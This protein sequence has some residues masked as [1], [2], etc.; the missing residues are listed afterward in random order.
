MSLRALPSPDAVA[1]FRGVTDL[2]LSRAGLHSLPGY[3]FS[4]ASPFADTL[5]KL[6]VSFNALSALPDELERCSKLKILF[7]AKNSFEALPAVLGK[8]PSLG[9]VSFK[10]NRIS[11]VPENSLPPS[12]YWLILTDNGISSLPSSIGRLE[13]LR[14]C[15]LSCNRLSALPESMANCT[16]LELLRLADND[17]SCIPPFLLS[18]PRLAWVALGGNLL[19]PNSKTDHLETLIAEVP[20]E[21]VVPRDAVHLGKLLGE[22]TSGK[23]FEGVLRLPGSEEVPCAVKTFK[24]NVTTSDGRPMDEAHVWTHLEATETHSEHL[25]RTLAIYADAAEH[26]LGVVMERLPGSVAALGGPPSFESVTRDVYDPER[27]F[28][29]EEPALERDLEVVAELAAGFAEAMAALHRGG[30]VHGDLYGHNLLVTAPGER[31]TVK[32]GDFGA[33]FLLP[34]DETVAGALMRIEVRSFGYFL[35]EMLELLA[36]RHGEQ[37]S[38]MVEGMRKLRDRCLAE[39]V[40]SRPLAAAVAA[41]MRHLRGRALPN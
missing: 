11:D 10:S 5:V 15:M 20:A 27:V 26:Q 8:L 3:L 14:K 36:A 13:G 22:G 6:D 25:V 28:G 41:E 1:A 19:P 17:F 24:D 2:D 18:L 38:G 4:A 23:I 33:G 7:A 29:S 9:M 31:R 16:Q 35:E 34:P 40:G 12:V 32:M 37:R 39:D 21:H 30:V